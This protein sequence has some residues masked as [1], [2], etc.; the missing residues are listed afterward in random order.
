MP[1]YRGNYGIEC[2]KCLQA[3]NDIQAQTS[4][5]FYRE[6]NISSAYLK[7]Y[8]TVVINEVLA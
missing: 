8:Y 7:M 1:Q 3:S 4:S 5:S 2:S 6:E